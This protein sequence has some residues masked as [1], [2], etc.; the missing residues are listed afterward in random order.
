MQQPVT[1]RASH[2]V[3]EVATRRVAE[4]PT[5]RRVADGDR[6]PASRRRL[7]T[8]IVLATA[9]V[10]AA[11]PGVAY[12]VRD[13]LGRDVTLAAAPRRIV[14]LVPS[15]T[16]LLFALGAED[17]LVGVTDY[18]DFPPAARKKT[19]V[20]GM[21]GPS[22][23][24][25]VALRPDVVIA[26]RDGNR[27]ETF[28]ELQR[29]G[30]PV[31]VVGAR[32]I[33]ESM[34]VIRHLAQLG[35]RSAAGGL[36]IERMQTRVAAV[37]KAVAGLRPPRVLYV[38]WPEPLIVPARDALVTELIDVAGGDSITAG[39]T[40]TY[41]RFSMEAAVARNPE[42]VVL[43]THGGG[44]APSPKGAWERLGHLA[45]VKAGRVNAVDGNLLHRYGPRMLDGLETLARVFHPEAFR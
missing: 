5:Y 19:S 34:E 7:V 30:I 8:L 22:L 28:I 38:V 9:L 21:V 11:P 41:P 39:E 32:R 45:S 27:E 15:V 26:T 33:A 18:C 31:Y 25:I 1:P 44:S 40:G 6:L 37:R 23:E 2:G 36:L 29:L 43:S 35:E 3:V 13:M 16:E 12:T 24:A 10:V 17:R 42:I 14:S 4:R 20:G